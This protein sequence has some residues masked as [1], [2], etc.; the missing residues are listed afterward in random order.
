MAIKKILVK[1]SLFSFFLLFFLNAGISV[2]ALELVYPPAPGADP[3]QDFV[4]IVPSSE[5]LSLYVKYFYNLSMVIGALAAFGVM[6]YSGIKY[7]FSLEK[8]GELALIREGFTSAIIGLLILLCSYLLL[9]AINPEL[10]LLSVNLEEFVMPNPIPPPPPPTEALI[11]E[12]FQVPLGKI[13]EETL[14]DEEAEQALEDIKEDA[15]EIEEVSERLAMANR[16]LKDYIINNCRCGASQCA[17]S[18][19]D[20]QAQ[21]CPSAVCDTNEIARRQREIFVAI[22]ELIN[23]GNQIE[24]AAQP[25]TEVFTEMAKASTLISLLS[26]DLMDYNT[27]T[28]DKWYAEKEDIETEINTFPGWEDILI[29]FNGRRVADP[30]TFYFMVKAGRR[31]FE[32]AERAIEEA[33]NVNV[34]FPFPSCDIGGGISVF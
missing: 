5:A 25:L 3:P 27:M 10:T 33:R 18:G 21:A 13:I 31:T 6:V 23:A 30:A 22:D 14:F 32:E 26:T 15:R 7:L 11:Y 17:L 4:G 24:E 1:I 19:Q 20:C 2:F 29:D 16:E 34:N 9:S 8:P 28:V 12:Y